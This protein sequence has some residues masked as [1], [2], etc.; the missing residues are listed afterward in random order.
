MT[1]ME[2]ILSAVARGALLALNPTAGNYRRLRT[3]PST[4][5][6]TFGKA[7]EETG[8]SIRRAMDQENR[9]RR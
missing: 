2:A 8:R 4:R 6:N 7:W 1:T 5:D 9:R 3:R